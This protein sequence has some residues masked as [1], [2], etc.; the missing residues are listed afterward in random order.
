LK[1]IFDGVK[2]EALVFI[3]HLRRVGTL[4]NS[5]LMTGVAFTILKYVQ[6]L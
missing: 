2:R 3:M 5:I 1:G 4:L 6:K